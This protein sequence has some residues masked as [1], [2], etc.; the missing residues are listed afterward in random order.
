M[1]DLRSLKAK[2]AVSAPRDRPASAGSPSTSSRRARRTTRRVLSR[3]DRRVVAAPARRPRRR[4]R[5]VERAPAR[6]ERDPPA[7]GFDPD[8]LHAPRLCGR[9]DPAL[10]LPRPQPAQALPL[11]RAR[12]GSG[13][14]ADDA[15]RRDDVPGLRRVLSERDAL[16][17][18]GIGRRRRRGRAAASGA[19]GSATGARFKA[20]VFTAG[21]QA[22]LRRARRRGRYESYAARFAA[23]EAVAKALGLRR[24]AG[25]ES[26]RRRDR[27]RSR[28]PPD[29]AP[30]RR[31][32]RDR[33]RAAGV[34]QVHVALDAYPRPRHSQSSPRQVAEKGASASLLPPSLVRRSSATPPRS[35]SRA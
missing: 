15:L 21:E 17:I 35:V 33:R 31:G 7:D 29:G 6:G 2:I 9:R 12:A 13:G 4:R 20:R 16:A 23:K 14:A 3:G 18:V 27:P 30:P 26:A 5:L 28:R 34:T 19:R 1:E 10:G 11:G 8:D 24:R 32:G 22:L 25:S